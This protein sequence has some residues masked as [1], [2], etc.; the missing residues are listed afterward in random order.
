MRARRQV[1]IM[2]ATVIC[3]F[4]ICLLPFRLFT[5]FLLF[6]NAQTLDSIGME[7]YYVYLYISRVSASLNN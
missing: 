5:L 1:V 7:S 2:L 6:I 4:F 3:C